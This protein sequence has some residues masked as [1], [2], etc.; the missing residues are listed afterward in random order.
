MPGIA[1][2][3]HCRRPAALDVGCGCTSPRSS[4]PTIGMVARADA[5]SARATVQPLGVESPA[6][7]PRRGG[8][9]TPVDAVRTL[10]V[11]ATSHH[12]PDVLSMPST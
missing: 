12:G 11:R 9:W 1:P 10:V 8:F 3:D 6:T 4:G 7:S 5:K 2:G